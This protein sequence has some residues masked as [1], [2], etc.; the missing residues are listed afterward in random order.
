MPQYANQNDDNDNTAKMTIIP[1]SSCTVAQLH[2]RGRISMSEYWY[3]HL[4]EKLDAKLDTHRMLMP[5]YFLNSY[6]IKQRPWKSLWFHWHLGKLFTVSLFDFFVIHTKPVARS[7]SLTWADT[8]PDH[9]GFC[10][11]LPHP[12]YWRCCVNLMPTWGKRPLNSIELTSGVVNLRIWK[13]DQR[14]GK[15]KL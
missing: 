14:P 12:S 5:H 1:A 7:S 4:G 10:M 6:Y 13:A 11:V 2:I 8:A 3:H 9:Q 15:A